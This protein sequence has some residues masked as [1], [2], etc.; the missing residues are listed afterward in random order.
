MSVVIVIR[1][2]GW[3][4]GLVRSYELIGGCMEDVSFLECVAIPRTD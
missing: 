3:K 4:D 2:V 1:V